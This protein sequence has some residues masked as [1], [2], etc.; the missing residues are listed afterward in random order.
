MFVGLSIAISPKKFFL[1]KGAIN[2]NI[3]AMFI[4]LN[5]IVLKSLTPYGSA[6]VIMV[7]LS[8][9]SFFLFPLVMKNPKQRIIKTLKTNMPL[10]LL[11]FVFNLVAT[12][13]LVIALQKGPASVVNAIYQGMLILSVIAGII[14]LKERHDVFKKILGATI[15][16]V[17][18]IL[19]VY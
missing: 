9:P 6:P 18:L 17:G 2:A 4:A 8:L 11:A 10:K 1:D 13:L 7:A 19:L 15:T 12:Y 14:L 5:I 3:A 16:I